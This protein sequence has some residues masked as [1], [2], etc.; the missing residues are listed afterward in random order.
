MVWGQQGTYASFA[1][2]ARGPRD[3]NGFPIREDHLRILRLD[4]QAGVCIPAKSNCTGYQIT[5]K[6]A[7]IGRLDRRIL[8]RIIFLKIIL[9]CDRVDVPDGSLGCVVSGPGSPRRCRP[10]S[11][12]DR[13]AFVP[14]DRG[15]RPNS[16]ARHFFVSGGRLCKASRFGPLG[17]KQLE[18]EAHR[19]DELASANPSHRALPPATP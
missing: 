14:A 9:E 17:P 18:P 1:S 19:Q 6:E 16:K 11:V 15:L 12:L 7:R 4:T 2:L 8:A 3:A 5:V 10:T 13:L